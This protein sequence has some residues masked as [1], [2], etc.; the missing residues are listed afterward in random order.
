MA[1]GIRRQ[2]TAALC[3]LLILGNLG[4]ALKLL[5]S[6]HDDRRIYR[7]IQDEHKRT[8]ALEV[9]WRQLL[10]EQSAWQGHA[11]VEQI[12]RER[13]EMYIPKPEEV[14]ILRV[15]ERG[16][17][18]TLRRDDVERQEL[19]LSGA[20]WRSKLLCLLFVLVPMILI[21]RAAELQV[22]QGED[23]D[24][25]FLQAKG[26]QQAA[27]KIEVEVHRGMVTDRHGQPLAVSIPLASLWVVP[28]EIDGTDLPAVAAALDLNENVL[29][30]RL[31]RYRKRNSRFMYLRRH[32]P[33]ELAERLL[34]K[35]ITGVRVRTEYQRFYPTG[36]VSAGLIGLTNV[37]D[38]G[39]EGLELYQDKH[40]RGTPG[41][42]HVIQDRAGR[43][44]R[45]LESLEPAREGP[46]VVTSLD[47][48]IQ[49]VAYRELKRAVLEHDAK[50]GSVVVLDVTTGEVL[51]M[52]SQP[53]QNPNDRSR[54]EIA[55]MRNIAVSNVFEPGSTLK[56]F[57]VLAALENGSFKPDDMIDTNP[58]YTT[59][60]GKLIHDPRNYGL[61]SLAQ[62]VA[63]SS[64]VGI[65]QVALAVPPEE[66]IE[67]LLSL[68]FG[69]RTGVGL[70]AEEE[71]S[72][73]QRMRLAGHR[74]GKPGIWL[75][76]FRDCTAAG[77]SLRRVGRRGAC[78]ARSD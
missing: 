47:Q 39:Q 68:G 77:A 9:H 25:R 16:S 21:Y 28:N 45:E 31:A 35:D 61:L 57:A 71:G 76:C 63:R 40:L 36:E 64:Q 24:F 38:R 60:S 72:V 14:V 11:R 27:R 74:A 75:R 22:M 54:L 2:F 51:A 3:L 69:Q 53:S 62:V 32:I 10:L 41:R 13:L 1:I 37:D 70:P 4:T 46:E 29:A 23:V 5:L 12:A 6:V 56:P 59:I 52:V 67:V 43:I 78:A 33:P 17:M 65:S 19:Q 7:L 55:K 48:R 49:Y 66:I 44:I 30:R 42:R 26:N 18:N 20:N 15:A 34:A 8:Q 73:P 58:G 50:G